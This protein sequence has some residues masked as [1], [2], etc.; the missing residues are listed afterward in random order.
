VAAIQVSGA[1]QGYSLLSFVYNVVSI[2]QRDGKRGMD[3][4]GVLFCLDH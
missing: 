2:L 1:L 3:G 4:G